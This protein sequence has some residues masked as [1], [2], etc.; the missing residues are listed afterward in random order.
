MP[1]LQGKAVRDLILLIEDVRVP[2]NGITNLNDH[3]VW[4][5]QTKGALRPSSS[6]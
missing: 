3:H 1:N 5:S 6:L 2:R 4:N